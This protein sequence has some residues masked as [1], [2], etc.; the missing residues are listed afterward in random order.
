MSSPRS[1]GGA[2]LE[3]AVLE[4]PCSSEATVL[5]GAVLGGAVLRGAALGGGETQLGGR[6]QT[7]AGGAAQGQTLAL[8][9]VPPQVLFAAIGE[10][11]LLQLQ[12]F[13]GQVVVVNELDVLVH[14]LRNQREFQRGLQLG[15]QEA[16]SVHQ[17][18]RL[19]AGQPELR[20]DQRLRRDRPRE[21]GHLEF[22]GQLDFA[23]LGP[24]I[25]DHPDNP[26]GL[27]QAVANVEEQGLG[28]RQNALGHAQ[29]LRDVAGRHAA[30]DQRHQD[31]AL[32]GVVP[33]RLGA[34]NLGVLPLGSGLAGASL[35][36][37]PP[38]A[39][40]LANPG[41]L[42]NLAAASAAR[43]KSCGELNSPLGPAQT[44]VTL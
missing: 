8:E 21:V 14:P 12:P 35:L 5:G 36:P 16:G 26:F 41:V 39:D 17:Q 38:E 32:V 37:K 28:R 23:G 13:R 44:A 30:Q 19:S 18:I 9:F 25:D 10:L 43:V 4:R 31:D 40:I 2:V 27:G 3:A 6:C 34:G 11:E 22:D 7:V 29:P 24:A 42:Q 33:E 15:V 1:L 20:V